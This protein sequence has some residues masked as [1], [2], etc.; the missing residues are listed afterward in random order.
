MSYFSNPLRPISITRGG[1]EWHGFRADA[2]RL[3][4]PFLDP[5]EKIPSEGIDEGLTA[6]EDVLLAR[7]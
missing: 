6:R 4:F 2:K 3:L 1:G 7:E 5:G